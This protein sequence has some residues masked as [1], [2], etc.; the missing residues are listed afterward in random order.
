MVK[1]VTRA[2]VELSDPR[3]Y[4]I[5]LCKHFAHKLD[6]DVGE[7]SATISSPFGFCTLTAG[8]TKLSIVASEV[9]P[10]QCSDVEHFIADH[11]K[12]FAYREEPEINWSR[13][14]ANYGA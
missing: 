12:R 14:E 3:L 10:D 7:N 6:V 11:L 2:D 8:D 5:R 9:A 13:S 1:M 4:M